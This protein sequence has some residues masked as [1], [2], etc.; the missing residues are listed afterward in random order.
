[1]LHVH[2]MENFTSVGQAHILAGPG[3]HQL[4]RFRRHRSARRFPAGSGVWGTAI[5]IFGYRN[6]TQSRTDYSAQ[7][8]PRR[9]VKTLSLIGAVAGPN[10]YGI[11]RIAMHQSIYRNPESPTDKILYCP[12]SRTLSSMPPKSVQ[13]IMAKINNSSYRTPILP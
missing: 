3:P 12:T 11:Y 7:V 6:P 4:D 1:M 5:W 2:T 9:N 8:T 10:V 13:K